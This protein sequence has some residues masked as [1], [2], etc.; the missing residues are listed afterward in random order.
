MI[1]RYFV[2]ALFVFAHALSGSA[3][4][5]GKTAVKKKTVEVSKS[6]SVKQKRLGVDQSDFMPSAN[7]FGFITSYRVM[8]DSLEQEDPKTVR[9]AFSFATTYS[10]NKAWSAYASLAVRFQ[11]HNFDVFRHNDTDQFYNLSNL[12]IGAVYTK[13]KPIPYVIRSSNTFNIS[14]PTSERS[15]VDKHVGSL[16]YTNF[17]QSASWKNFS[18]FNRFFTSYLWNTHK[19]SITNDQ[20][21]RDFLTSNS[22]G[23]NY[24]P[25]RWVGFRISQRVDFERNLNGQW[26]QSFGGNFSMFSNIKGVQVFLSY[27]NSA[28]AENDRLDV[29]F[30]D[31]YRRMYSLGVTY[32]F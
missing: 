8:Y 2:I 7:S 18:L 16:S 3:K 26:T 10:F 31:K 17:M 27:I 30:F 32:A 1:L 6:Q 9:N 25:V 5:T 22:L 28:Y 13:V 12:N 21:N 19:F 11:T 23:V 14:L 4:E 29:S 20:L 15:L 24:F